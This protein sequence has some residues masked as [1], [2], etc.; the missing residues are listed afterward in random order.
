MLKKIKN[1]YF[2]YI[3]IAVRDSSLMELL[4]PSLREICLSRM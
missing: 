1:I 3:E 4:I 2:N